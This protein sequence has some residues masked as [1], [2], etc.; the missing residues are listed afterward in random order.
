MHRALGAS[1]L[2]LSFVS[3]SEAA[4]TVLIFTDTKS[5]QKSKTTDSGPLA[6]EEQVNSSAA[7]PRSAWPQV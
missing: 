3:P 7:V 1:P 2:I 4:I 6:M 5:N